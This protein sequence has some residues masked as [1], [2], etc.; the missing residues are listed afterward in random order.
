MHPWKNTTKYTREVCAISPP[1]QW[2][3]VTVAGERAASVVCTSLS[4]WWLEWAQ[5]RRG[6]PQHTHIH[7]HMLLSASSLSPVTAEQWWSEASLARSWKTSEKDRGGGAWRTREARSVFL[8]EGD[9]AALV[10]SVQVQLLPDTRMEERRCYTGEMRPPLA[11][12]IVRLTTQNICNYNKIN[13]W[14]QCI[15]ALSTIVVLTQKM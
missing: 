2:H 8:A 12:C 13:L 7:T 3:Y 1:W 14:V 6:F 4:L 11:F 5:K 9:S 15:F 10:C